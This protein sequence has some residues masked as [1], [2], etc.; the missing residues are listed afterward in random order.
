MRRIA[1]AGLA[2]LGC[3]AP[4]PSAEERPHVWISVERNIRVKT[5]EIRGPGWSVRKGVLHGGKQE[6]VDVIVVDNGRLRIEIVPTRGMGIRSVTAGDVRLGWDSPVKE[7]VH[8]K[9]VDLASRGGLGWLEG[10]NEWMCRCGLEWAGHPGTDR[11]VN[12]V[13]DEATMELTLHGKAANTPAC[14]VEVLVTGGDAPRIRVRGRVDERMFYGPK[15]ELWTEVSTEP[16]SSSFRIADVLTNR[17][18]QPQEFQMIYHA[19]FGRPLLE[20]GSRFLA[21]AERV[22]PFNDHAAKSA[23][24]YGDYAPPSNG[25]I[26]QVY[27]LRMHADPAGR[28]AAMIENRA[29]DRGALMSWAAKELPYFTLWKNTNAEKEGYVTGLEPGTGFPY[30][31]RLERKAGRVPKLAPGAAHAMAVEVEV[32]G[33]AESVRRAE[34]RIESIRAGRPTRVDERPDRPE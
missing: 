32:L 5:D 27:C 8:P 15:L 13:G 30:N 10:F 24:A 21:P 19:N 20:G 23:S 11:F 34:A 26:E 18:D 22:T 1:L 25:F 31:R 9:H 14:E 2:L 16:L 3:R 28:T 12:N 33:D 6:G 17:G 29:R 7:T 4:A